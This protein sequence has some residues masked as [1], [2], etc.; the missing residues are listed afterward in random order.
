MW[1]IGVQ[2]PLR[3]GKR[4][5]DS[6]LLRC[7]TKNALERFS[8]NDALCMDLGMFYLILHHIHLSFW[9]RR[10]YHLHKPTKLSWSSFFSFSF[11][12]LI[13][14]LSGRR[15]KSQEALGLAISQWLRGLLKSA[16]RNALRKWIE[17][18]KLCILN[19]G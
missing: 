6:V 14:F 4:V 19:C 10:R 15:Y 18:L 9:T 13:K 3:K 8:K 17:R 5:I 1:C 16:Y 12:N 2:V 11:P 7:Y